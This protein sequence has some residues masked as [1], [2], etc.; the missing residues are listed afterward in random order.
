V[1]M[2][3]AEDKHIKLCC[4]SGRFLNGSGSDFRKRPDPDTVL[5]PDPDPDLTKFSGN[6]FPEIFFSIKICS[7]KY[8]HEPKS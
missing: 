3:W 8:L 4:G 7:K 1:S 6:F 2:V 5:D